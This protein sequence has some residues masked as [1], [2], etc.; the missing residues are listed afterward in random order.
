M[1]KILHAPILVDEVTAELI[2]AQ[3]QTDQVRLRRVARV[4]PYGMQTALDVTE[5]LPP[6]SEY[7]ELTNRDLGHYEAAVE[8]FIAGDWPLAFTLLDRVPTFDRVKD[9][10][11]VRIAEHN[12]MAP[13]DWN[14]VIDLASKR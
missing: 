13:P 10:L 6:E 3:T 7:P 9:F 12:R 5:L 8:A 11:L 4:K 2:R 1:T 14:G